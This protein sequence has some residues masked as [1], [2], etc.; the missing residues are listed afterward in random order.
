MRK[1]LSR[2]AGHAS[3]RGLVLTALVASQCAL[4]AAP[5]VASGSASLSNLQL[6]VSDF[7]PDDGIT[8][9]AS[10]LSRGV[11]SAGV[12]CC[13][14]NLFTDINMYREMQF[15]GDKLVNTVVNGVS[16]AGGVASARRTSDGA[17]TSLVIDADHIG[18]IQFGKSDISSLSASASVISGS[19]KLLLQPGTEIELTGWTKFD[20][21]M[22]LL[23]MPYYGTSADPFPTPEVLVTLE[24]L[25]ELKVQAQA[26]SNSLDFLARP[27]G[28]QAFAGGSVY[29][30]KS[31]GVITEGVGELHES[32][33]F[34]YVIRNNGDQA[35]VLE[36]SLSSS[37]HFSGNYTSVSSIPEPESIALALA[38]LLGLAWSRRRQGRKPASKSVALCLSAAALLPM[39]AQATPTVSATGA[40]HAVDQLGETTGGFDIDPQAEAFSALAQGDPVFVNGSYYHGQT[41]ARASHGAGG[42][43]VGVST[44]EWDDSVL[45]DPAPVVTSS[46]SLDWSDTIVNTGSQA[47]SVS[48]DFSTPGFTSWSMGGEGSFFKLSIWIEGQALPVWSTGVSRQ[49]DAAQDRTVNVFSGQAMGLWDQGY[50][51]GAPWSG[52]VS[53]GSLGA[54]DS[55]KVHFSVEMF[56]TGKAAL[57]YFN[58]SEPVLK[59]A[60]SPVPEP[61]TWAMVFAGLGLIGLTARRRQAA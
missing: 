43:S 4:A 29:Q 13:D 48:L 5:I 23:N 24:G 39:D 27:Q 46:V 8:A 57:M 12:Y 61:S 14:T 42:L 52:Q 7:R 16:L 25:S 40:I 41:L 30:Y 58:S 19:F 35:Q 34:S 6:Q 9:G 1:T 10:W 11:G 55:F 20:A 28:P 53:L 38:G 17:Q 45:N 21:S 32:N 44:Y 60:V 59:M 3:A 47:R 51:S 54:S 2:F 37:L 18:S 33:P 15:S 22:N 36:L 26:G 56:A 50:V 31:A 49:F